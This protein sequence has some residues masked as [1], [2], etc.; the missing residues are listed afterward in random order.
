MCHLPLKNVFPFPLAP[1]KWIG[2]L[3]DKKRCGANKTFLLITHQFICA[4]NVRSV[5]RDAVRS[6]QEKKSACSWFTL[7]IRSASPLTQGTPMGH[8]VIVCTASPNVKV[9]AYSFCWRER[10]RKYVSRLQTA[11]SKRKWTSIAT[12]P[13]LS[14][15]AVKILSHL[16]SCYQLPLRGQEEKD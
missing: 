2:D 6:E 1:E 15:T 11:C 8:C 5:K 16:I 3:F 12:V 9:I 10:K 13:D 7:Q 14:L 4:Q